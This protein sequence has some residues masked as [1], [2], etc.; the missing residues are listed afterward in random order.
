MQTGDC[1]HRHVWWRIRLGAAR[2]GARRGGYG[3]S[4]SRRR[5][6]LT[7]HSAVAPFRA[8]I[9][10]RTFLRHRPQTMPAPQ[11]SPTFRVVVAPASIA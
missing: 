5:I 4:Q 1:Q 6:A 8:L 10:A 3:H 7:G 11:D 2:G 9:M